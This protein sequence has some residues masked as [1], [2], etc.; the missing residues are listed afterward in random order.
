[1]PT[2]YLADW[3]AIQHRKQEVTNASNKQENKHCIPHEYHVGDKILI[4]KQINKLGKV[5]C[6][7]Q[8][9][10]VIV[11]VQD[12]PFNCTVVIDKGSYK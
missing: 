2:T 7:T 6:P 12:L 3:A 10:F 8:E 11:E 4:H 5:Q 1:M 9:P